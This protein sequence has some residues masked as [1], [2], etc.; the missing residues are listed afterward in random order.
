MPRHGCISINRQ[1]TSAM[2]NNFA[3][4]CSIECKQIKGV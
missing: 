3:V 2:E 4:K 1:F